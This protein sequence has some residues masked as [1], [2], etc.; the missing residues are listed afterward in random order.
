MSNSKKKWKKKKTA[1]KT[2]IAV[3]ITMMLLM[4]VGLVLVICGAKDVIYTVLKTWGVVLLILS[5]PLLIKIVYQLI[6]EK[7]D[8]I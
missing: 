5:I 7:I 8:R 4:L 1:N 6:K 2:D 3:L